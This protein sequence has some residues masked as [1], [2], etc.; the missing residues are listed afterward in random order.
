[1][2]LLL[3]SELPAGPQSQLFDAPVHVAAH[4]R[5]DGTMV[6]AHVRIQKVALK[7]PQQHFLF[8]HDVPAGPEKRTRLQQFVD[9]HGGHDALAA[10]LR[11]LTREQQETLYERMAGLDRANVEDVRKRFADVKPRE[12]E[13]GQTPD[14]FEQ[15]DKPELVDADEHGE[16]P[17]G[18]I[19]KAKPKPPKENAPAP[20][21]EPPPPPAPTSA[22]TPEIQ[23]QSND[24]P[25]GVPAGISKAE[26][27]SINNQVAKLVAD[28]LV[29][30]N[31]M[32]QYSGNGGCGDSLNEFYTDPAIARAQ[33]AVIER[34]GVPRES[35]LEPSCGTGVF[36]HTAPEGTRVTGVELD[37]ISSACAEALHGDRHG[38]VGSTSLERF[39]R[40]DGGRQFD[41]VI[42]NPPYGPRG[43]L[44]KDDKPDLK[45]CEAYFIDTAIDKCKPGGII[46]LVIPASVLNAKNGRAF[47]ERMLRKAEFLGA[48][49]MPNTAFEASHTD[50]TADVLWLRK[51]PDDVAGA[52]MT[53]DK[54]KLKELGVWDDEF[55]AG[56]YFE[57]RGK[58]NVFGQVGT[59]MRSFGEVYTV[60]G[61]MSGVPG[62][63]SAFEP[64]P[65]T[66]TPTVQD[67]V[68]A[69]GDDEKAVAKAMGGAMVRPY[70]DGKA[71]D[72][73][74]VDGVTYVLQG[75]PLRW[76]RVDEILAHEAVTDAKPLA[77]MIDRAMSGEAVD[78]DALTAQ[79]Q[80]YIARH[81]LPSKSAQLTQAAAHDK[82]L[83]RLIGAVDQT[84]R[85]SDAVTG[86]RAVVATGSVQTAAETL[87]AE[88]DDQTFT[89]KDLVERSGRPVDEVEEL[90]LASQDYA[91]LGGDAWQ[92]MEAYLT[93]ELWPKLD[94]ARSM[95]K[96]RAED[97]GY[98]EKAALQVEKLEAV[99]SPKTLDDVEF[100]FNSG[101]IP[102][103]VIA[104]WMD[105]ERQALIERDPSSKYYRE[106]PDAKVEFRDGL[107]HIS[108][109]VWGRAEM[110]ATFLNRTGT[111]KDDMP[112]VEAANEEFRDWVLKSAYRDELETLYNRKFRG[113]VPP[114][115]S[116]TPIDVPGLD[117]A[118]GTRMPNDY[119]W[120]SLRWALN[121][122]KGIIADDVGLGKTV[123]GLMLARL[124]K[125]YGKAKKPTF[126]VPKSVLANWVAEAEMWF[127]GSRILVIGETYSRDKDGGLKSKTDS[128]AERN[129]KYHDLSQ[130]DYD[131]VFISRDSFNE[132]DV[133]PITKGEYLDQDFWVQRGDAL[134]NAGDKKIKR[135]REQYKQAVADREFGKRT[136]AIYFNDLG[137]D[138][139]IVDE[140][141]AYKNLYAAR[142]RFGESPKFLGG[143]GQS[144]RAFDMSFKTKWLRD[145]HGGKGIYALTATPTKNSPLEVY[146]MLSYIAPEEFEK[147]GIRNSEDFLDRYC[148][149]QHEN[150]LGTNGEIDD[151]LVTVGFKNLD[152]LR[153]IMGRY[154][155]RR[156]AADVG[157]KLPEAKQEMHLV[158]MS[159]S[160]SA[161]YGEL[162]A[163]LAE[164]SKKDSTGDAHV[165]SIMDKMAKAA[166]DLELLDADNY[167]GEVSPKY[168]A[169]A[170][171][172]AEASKNGG[173][174]VFCEAV[175]SHEK[176]AAALVA[177]GIPRSRI[178]ILNAAAASSSAARQNISDKFNDGRLDVVI[179]NK[180]MEE[181]VNLQ[182]RTSDI[183]HL[184]TPWDPA[185]LQQRNGRGL[186]QGNKK[187]AVNLHTYLARGS[188]DGYRYQSMRAKRD[189]MEMLWNGGDR[190]DNLA[191]EGVFSREDMMVMMAADPEA[192]R[193]KLAADKEAAMQRLKAE[194]IT[195]AAGEF[196]R[197]QSLRRSF[198]GLKNK[199]TDS[200]RRLQRQIHQAKAGLQHNPYFL[201]KDALDSNE[202]V[203][204]NPGTGL[205]IKRNIAFEVDES[206]GGTSKW[207]VTGVD[208]LKQTVSMRRYADTTGHKGV[209]IPVDRLAKGTKEFKFDAD[210]EAKQVGQALE[211]EAG[212]KLETIS[213]YDDV[214]SMP[215]S[216][217]EANHDLLQRKMKEGAK[218]YKF[219]FPFGNVPM[220]N[221]ETG[222]IEMMESYDHNRR[223]ETHDYLL[224]TDANKEKA[225]QAYIEARRKRKFEITFDQVRSG[226]GSRS[227]ASERRAKES[228]ADAGAS[229]TNRHS[230]P[231]SS[232]LNQLSPKPSGGAY[233]STV[234]RSP[235]EKLAKERMVE[236]QMARVRHAKTA[237]EALGEAM[238]MGKIIGSAKEGTAAV[239]LP[240]K[241][242]AMIW[243]RAKIN[244]ELD[245]KVNVAAPKTWN[246]HSSYVFARGDGE[247]MH[248]ALVRMAL[249]GG[250]H[251]LAMSMARAAEKH[252]LGVP[253]REVHDSLKPAFAGDPLAAE[254]A[255]HALRAAERG[256]FADERPPRG[257]Y[258]YSYSPPKKTPRE[259]LSEMAEEADRITAQRAK[260]REETAA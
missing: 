98:P 61:S 118:G 239:A 170:K 182:K 163:M 64:H 38:I 166:L 249:A 143:Q 6:D 204:L 72:T 63:I 119:H 226:R 173:Q 153:E 132:L 12:P 36:L 57:G 60:N 222:A 167:A 139:L 200:A 162:R 34:L 171:Q 225:I 97:A 197:F 251:A 205:A 54:A 250:H 154:I 104:A 178:A 242:L 235:L 134:G 232:L 109:G 27:R 189:W 211:A 96:I 230:N 186:R 7:P 30:K 29:D 241:A 15:A 253:D 32:R 252:S 158:D 95:G 100:G 123:R 51:R 3:K 218:S 228:Y 74:V 243:A 8:H 87:A 259:S 198:D 193:A 177:A 67:V 160:Q 26:R 93:G 43:S 174:V 221:R 111:K 46:S 49:R 207:V 159:P 130:N 172:I 210:A 59:A 113:F 55:L 169:A 183:H 187:E 156:T 10:K 103:A 157:L 245:K 19:P 196:V 137:V 184:D 56:T 102:P 244:G 233:Y 73:K 161:V 75:R 191:R 258:D 79:V 208:P 181:G 84:G 148:V 176:I 227:G 37:P 76:H 185:T 155:M 133:D 206:E 101:F 260:A 135:V 82:A 66:S 254:R 220:V 124:A 209:V 80:A 52:L 255:R 112:K 142:A 40:S 129:R 99:I 223:H 110:L 83:Y 149:F 65:V 231:I 175:D 217:L 39:A 70:A 78:H 14:L 86:R 35:A 192:E 188:F 257:S 122:G 23:P 202:D 246:R 58:G 62:E 88:R 1:M 21:P 212:A 44:A 28:G 107:Y 128:E 4:V 121:A 180:V 45:T 248:S 120:D 199:D 20:A 53:V 145:N 41:V 31:L 18:R 256:G 125:M 127:P 115:W 131:F 147:I 190:V 11:Q 229:Y 42:G 214:A 92:P 152:E 24:T 69:L 238:A 91:Y 219:S 116:R 13:K 77:D 146:S 150:V 117:N 195:K 71:G 203:L 114:K 215:S 94:L 17:P 201:A 240:E 216:V 9:K 2:L 5:K 81:G 236:Q 237:D 108:G 234:N 50:V 136:D 90:L 89:V 144:N 16:V 47:R 68:A 25:F 168:T 151:A 33:W 85:L 126:A 213:S 194:R 224:P 138:M 141:H 165:F 48:Q 105:S 179:G 140:A 247:T 106:L 164:T 22:P